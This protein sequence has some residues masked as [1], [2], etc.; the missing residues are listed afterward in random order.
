MLS[1]ALNQIAHSPWA[2]LM[3]AVIGV[4]MVVQIVA[5]YRLCASQV[6]RAQAREAMIMQQRNALS[7]CLDY[8]AGSTISS[9]GRQA[10]LQRET[11]ADSPM[12]R[13]MPMQAARPG[14]AVLSS[15]VPVSFVF[16]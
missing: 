11:H 14:H 10:A 9:C 2:R 13:E 7:D 8:L 6:E 15:A 3:W 5:F 16:H 4:L 1:R 12:A